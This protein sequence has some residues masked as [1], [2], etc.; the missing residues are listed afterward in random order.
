MADEH[1]NI[2]E[3][4]DGFDQSK[5][6]NP[7]AVDQRQPPSL[8]QWLHPLRCRELPFG[9]P[10][11]PRAQLLAICW[12]SAA[13][14]NLL[15]SD[16]RLK[17]EISRIGT[18]PLGFGVYRFKYLWSDQAYVGVLAQDLANKIPDAV[19]T[20]LGNFLAVDYAAPWHGHD[21]RG[22]V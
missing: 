18:H 11:R 4:L 5:C 21:T 16:R 1:H 10:K 19:M 14:S 20:G 6:E 3:A 17:R 8:H 22:V 7:H 12:K 13:V 2:R 9:W 15:E